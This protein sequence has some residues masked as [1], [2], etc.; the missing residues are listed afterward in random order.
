VTLAPGTRFG[1]YDVPADRVLINF[2]MH[3]YMTPYL[4]GSALD[5]EAAVRSVG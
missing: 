3:P 2:S 5:E 1:P 4:A